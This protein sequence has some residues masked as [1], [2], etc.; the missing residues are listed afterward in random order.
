MLG[1]KPNRPSLCAQGKRLM[2]RMAAI[3]DGLVLPRAGGQ[4][5]KSVAFRLDDQDIA[6]LS[7]LINIANISDRP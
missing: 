3:D 2:S 7:L 5:G 4:R 6:R 1:F